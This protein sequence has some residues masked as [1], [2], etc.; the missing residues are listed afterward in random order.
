MNKVDWIV[1]SIFTVLGLMVVGAFVSYSNN[2]Q[3]CLDD[4]YKHWECHAM[5]NG[6]GRFK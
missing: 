5:L 1:I 6:G 4:G 3:A 2:F